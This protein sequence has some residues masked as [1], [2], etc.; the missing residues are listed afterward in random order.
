MARVCQHYLRCG[1]DAA[2]ERSLPR[3]IGG[4]VK[5]KEQWISW[6]AVGGG[7]GA[8][9]AGR[10]SESSS[11]TTHDHNCL[12]VPIQVETLSGFGGCLARAAS[13]CSGFLPISNNCQ[14][15]FPLITLEIA[16]LLVRGYFT[17]MYVALRVRIGLRL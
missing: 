15:L 13:R 11:R 16:F 2:G 17:S 14:T 12:R 10:P 5:V 7:G 3:P 4:L 8:A 6:P 9:S 1:H